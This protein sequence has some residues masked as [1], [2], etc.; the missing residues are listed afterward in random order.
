MRTLKEFIL[1]AKIPIFS[2][3]ESGVKEFCEYVF[4]P[5]TVKYIINPD[6]TITL[7]SLIS[8]FNIYMDTKDLVE[9][10]EFIIFSNIEKYNI[11]LKNSKCKIKYWAP[12]VNGY[13][14]G[15]I[16]NN[17]PK[18]QELDLSNCEIRGG[19]LD[20]EMTG[21]K[22]I[23][24]AHGEDVRVF[25]KKN[26]NLGKIDLNQIK[27]CKHGSWITNNKNLLIKPSDIPHGIRVE[28]NKLKEKIYI[29]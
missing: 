4:D 14:G 20:I 19:M 17:T 1:E 8:S 23:T 28:N 27:S 24:G 9:I 18:V 29:S 11:G 7:E 6:L 15:I 25:I 12:K 26:K 5:S 2:N 22:S 3:D 10:P 16:V 13:C 21:I